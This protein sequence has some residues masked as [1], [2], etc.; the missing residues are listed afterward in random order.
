MLQANYFDGRSTRVRSVNLSVAGEDLIVSGEDVDLRIPFARVQVDER[1]GRAPR[2]L[3][4]EGGAFFEVRD[5]GA[6]DSL[7]SAVGHRDGWVDRFQR[8]LPLV[9]LALVACVL[10]AAGA[11]RWGLPWAAAT[12]ARHLSPAVGRVLS[13]Q[14]LKVLDG[15]FLLPSKIA[16]EHQQRLSAAFHALRLPDGGTPQSALLFRRSPQLG[17]NAFTLPDGT[18]IL[19]DDLIT[20]LDD[21]Q[22]TLAVLA[23]ELGHAHERHGLQ[24]LL[25]SSAIGAFLTF[26]VGDISTLLAAAPAAVVEARYSREFER[27]AD[28]YAA[29]LLRHNGMSPGLLADALTRLAELQPAFSKGRYL[30]SHPSSDE[31]IR[32]LRQPASPDTGT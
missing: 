19:L 1:L 9:L 15:G 31:R 32:R 11:Y 6:L 22:Q 26:Y 30:A 4:L 20:G 13:A 29:R 12:G 21:D 16:E 10:C 25:R 7:L 23:H 28:D 3:R 24:M 17:A 14:T 5:L 27:Q 2:R 8:R 18:I